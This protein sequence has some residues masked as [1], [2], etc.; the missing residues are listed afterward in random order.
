MRKSIF[1]LITLFIFPV[2][3]ESLYNAY[4]NAESLNGY[5]RYVVLSPDNIYTG[6]LGIFEGSVFIE[7]NGAVIDLESG[8]GIWVYADESTPVSLIIDRCSVINGAYFGVNFAG[9]S[10]GAV[11]NCNLINT[12][13][14][15]QAFDFSVVEVK[16][17]N[18]INNEVYGLAIYSTNPQVSISYC[19]AWNNGEDYME[20]C[21]G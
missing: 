13:M 21:P 17:C 16:N 8:G 19:N 14:G 4:Q 20:N 5:D 11:R 6:G 15:F 18:L 12:G 7:G 1:L 10:T 9:Y 3:G 2:Y